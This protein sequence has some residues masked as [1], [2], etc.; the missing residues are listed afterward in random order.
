M[1][2]LIFL[3]LTKHFIMDFLMQ[4]PYQYMNKGKLG[5]PGGILHAGLHAFATATILYSFAPMALALALAATD[6]VVH[7]F[8]DWAKVNTN[9]RLNLKPD[10]SDRFWWLFG[11]DQWLHHV[12]YIL[13][14]FVVYR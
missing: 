9:T 14:A 10:N 3:L 6:G 13:I 2:W 11:F 8:I 5:H 1:L 7:Y 4:G 12:T